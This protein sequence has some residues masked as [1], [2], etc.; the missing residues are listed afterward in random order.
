MQL[1]CHSPF[2][3]IK[4]VVSKVKVK[5]GGNCMQCCLILNHKVQHV[6]GGVPV[7]GYIT[8]HHTLVKLEVFQNREPLGKELF[9]FVF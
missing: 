4:F 5:V 6:E 2:S 1:M 3:L 8:R 9:V 7:G